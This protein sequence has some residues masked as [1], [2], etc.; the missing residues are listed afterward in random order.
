M[1]THTKS[2]ISST[3]LNRCAA[4]GMMLIMI[5]AVLAPIQVNAASL[6]DKE[7]NYYKKI[8]T[9]KQYLEDS[10]IF[11]GGTFTLYDVNG[12]GRKELL[13]S[14]ALGLRSATFTIIYSY[15]GKKFHH[16]EVRGTLTKVSSKGFFTDSDDY[17]QAGAITYSDDT[18]FTLTKKGKAKEKYQESIV[19][20]YDSEK[21]TYNVTSHNYYKYKDGKQTAIKKAAYKK[22]V[23]SFEFKKIGKKVKAYEI[24]DENISKYV[25]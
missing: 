20:E 16:T 17:E 19:M 22:G 18:C 2:H 7:S 4:L 5:L 14:G 10:S 15:D 25:K 21:E 3:I 23:K 12:D 13:I 6:S 8:M 1:T 11:E 24:N 9:S